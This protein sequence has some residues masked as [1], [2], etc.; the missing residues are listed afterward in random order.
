MAPDGADVAC[1]AGAMV[2]P[3]FALLPADIR[4]VASVSAAVSRAGM[5]TRY[6][7]KECRVRLSR[8]AMLTS[9]LCAV[10]RPA[11]CL[12]ASWRTW[13]H[14]RATRCWRGRQPPSRAGLSLRTTPQDQMT[15]L[16]GRC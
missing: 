9:L 4:D 3:V 2:S 11:S 1:E 6:E 16:E 12:S 5:D 10:F 15:R 8:E 7:E 14:T 13:P